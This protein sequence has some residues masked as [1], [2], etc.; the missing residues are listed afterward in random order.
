MAR[1]LR[2]RVQRR[3]QPRKSGA[4]KKSFTLVAVL[5]FAVV[6]A[7][8]TSFGVAFAVYE[9]YSR[10]V[11]PPDELIREA[12]LGSAW[13]YDRNG[14]LLYQFADP[15]AGL[16][17]PVSIDEI[18]RPII[19]A[20]ISTEDSSFYT[21]PG[22]NI[23]GLFRA[24]VE[25]LLP[26]GSDVGFFQGSGGSSIT[27]QLVKNLYIERDERYRRSISRK[28]KET[29]IALELTNQ[30]SKDQILE[31][32]LNHIFYGNNSYGVESA[33]RR[34]FGKHASE[35]TLPEA[36]LLAGIPNSPSEY[37]P[38]ANPEAASQRQAEVLDLMV[39]SKYIT[40]QEADEAKAVEIVFR[41]S[42]E[43]DLLAPHWVFHLWNPETGEGALMDMCRQG[44]LE[45]PRGWTC[46]DLLQRGGLRVT[47][48]LDMELQTEAETVLRKWIA[49]F[50]QSS[51]G[52]NG[53]MMTIDNATGEVLVYI[54][55]R[56]YAN[57]D[58]LGKN[59]MITALNSPGSSFKPFT[60]ITA[61]TK[62]W[63]PASIIW[64]TPTKIIGGDGKEFEPIN[65]ARDYRGPVSV[66]TALGASLNVPAVKVM[67]EVGVSEVIDQAR[68]M[69][70]TSLVDKNRYG[71]ALTVGGGEVT[72]HDM[73]FAFSAFANNGLQRGIPTSRDGNPTW[74]PALQ[75][76]TVLSVTN[77]DGEE[78][79]KFEKPQEI[80][81]APAVESYLI[82]SILSDDVARSPT[83]GLGSTLNL[84][85]RTSGAK[86]GTSEPYENSR[87]IGETWTIG[88]TPQLVTGVWIGNADNSP[89]FNITSAT[90]AA[91]SWNEFM[92]FAH[93]HLD[94]PAASFPR[95][96][97]IVSAS[98]FVPGID[99]DRKTS[100]LFQQDNDAEYLHPLCTILMVDIRTGLPA[101]PDTPANLVEERL[102][103][104]VPEEV[105]DWAREKGFAPTPSPT[106][107]QTQTNPFAGTPTPTASPTNPFPGG[108]TSPTP[109]PTPTT[110]DPFNPFG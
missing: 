28:L 103:L 8:A 46:A 66:R 48:T 18:A 59:D 23:R 29:V 32:Y 65:P 82:T 102:A 68:T 91:R 93:R 97:G 101:A 79:Y 4:Q 50:E 95:P 61:F 34:Y 41:S 24:A 56:D 3:R 11:P 96:S 105:L 62:G 39:R 44:L 72:L 98:A 26:F 13:V 51:G 76:V 25:N 73:T 106:P 85:G 7:V 89:M 83:Y 22:V 5:L 21:N 77:S 64:D 99:C 63:A 37:D 100:D 35:L 27:Q 81:V 110:T 17:D 84:P 58:I 108:G 70:I 71:P 107:T 60:Y 53:A 31:W 20:T 94:L 38:F 69:G 49:E 43:S 12:A 55:S 47:T 78:L 15:D 19:E 80:R 2:R 14:I 74:W 36:A 52:H 75:P 109:T 86:T 90:I 57:A 9:R 92:T 54:G 6:A 67:A 33:S 1:A 104:D 88:Y 42:D 87:A 16:R 30:Y 10:D 45:R 40:Q